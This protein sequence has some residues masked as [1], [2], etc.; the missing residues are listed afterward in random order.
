MSINYS[1]SGNFLCQS[2]SILY[3][4]NA[5][6]DLGLVKATENRDRFFEGKTFAFLDELTEF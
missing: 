5:V 4:D 2:R 6:I 3:A 1:I